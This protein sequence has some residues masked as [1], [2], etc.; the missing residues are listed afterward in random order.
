MESAKQPTISRSA[1]KLQRWANEV[2]I[3]LAVLTVLTGSAQAQ[4]NE[5]DPLE[6]IVV[7]GIR[8]S[9]ANALRNKRFSESIRDG[10]SAEDIGKLPDVNI[11]EALQRVTGV[12]IAREVGEGTFVSIRG[13]DPIFTKVTIDGQSI[14][15]ARTQRFGQEGVNLSIISP[16]IA[17]SLEVIKAP[18]AAM[19]EGGVGGT[20]NINKVRPIDLGEERYS[21]T[22]EGVNDEFRD[23]TKPRINLFG[24]RQFADGKFGISAGAYYYDREVQRHRVDGDDS[25]RDFDDDVAVGPDGRPFIYQERVRV[26]DTDMNT[27]D[28]TL[29]A[30]LQY[31]P[32][33]SVEMYFDTI[34]SNRDVGRETNQ[35]N[36]GFRDGQINIAD[37]RLAFNAD[38]HLTSVPLNDFRDLEITSRGLVG[39]ESL[40]TFLAGAEWNVSDSLGLTFEAAYSKMEQYTDDTAL[41]DSVFD[42]GE[43]DVTPGDSSD[44]VAIFH[45]D[46]GD[47]DRS[48]VSF[49]DLTGLY[50][51]GNAE[52]FVT[53]PE[54]GS[55]VRTLF[56]EGEESSFKIDALKDLSGALSIQFGAKFTNVT[57]R[58]DR[59]R[60][61]LGDDV[62]ESIASAVAAGKASG[63]IVDNSDTA[64]LVPGL[65]ATPVYR[66]FDITQPGLLAANRTAF[67]DGV[68]DQFFAERDILALYTMLDFNAQWGRFPVS[69]NVG[70]RWLRDD[71]TLRG[72]GESL[73]SGGDGITRV[74]VDEFGRITDG[75]T[76]I[77]E[78]RDYN[79]VLPSLNLRFVLTDDVVGRFALA[80]VM[81]RPEIS[82]QTPYFELD[83]DLDSITEEID[84]DSGA[85]GDNGNPDLDPFLA[86]Q[87]DVS[88]EYY[89]GEIGLLSLGLFYKDVENF[90][91]SE[92][93][94][95]RILPVLGPDGVVRD[96]TLEV[97]QAINGGGASVAGFEVTVQRELSFLA[98]DGLGVALNYTYTDSEVDS[99]GQALPGTSKNSGNAAVFY[100]N[101]Q[102]GARLAYNTRGD[103]RNNSGTDYR[104]ETSSLDGSA[105]YDL[106][107]NVKLTFSAVNILSDE[108]VRR[109][110]GSSDFYDHGLS[111]SDIATNWT[112]YERNGRQVFFGVS[113]TF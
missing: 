33:D 42:D 18:T 69:G 10:V 22:A 99:D 41:V 105:Y 79:E 38:N 12:Q 106:T 97:E 75:Y 72:F 111:V 86:N 113:A 82:D 23:S 58:Q 90:I 98:F 45:F 28:M 37:S 104:L 2:L 15:A 40:R 9:Y 5:S 71:S 59:F 77:V 35:F 48:G 24:S 39:E 92:D 100:E 67:A 4:T 73:S 94:F 53:L 102:F 107:D 52:R 60:Q 47:D 70:V 108:F 83:F 68:D 66:V 16:T 95:T 19:D 101:A 20:V 3:S 13:L 32:G 87:I 11:A 36:L 80:R 74:E 88:I 81:R 31:L 61:V 96:V 27:E 84:F 65:G 57:E 56:T 43:F 49:E 7:E 44:T 46:V 91:D 93:M 21:A 103:W 25:P 29:S 26:E 112:S 50:D 17:S 6:E 64:A 54:A 14:T 110:R 89:T 78:E 51:F 8:G 109:L 76:Q 63:G 30:S 34:Y 55:S 1:A 85:S 62:R